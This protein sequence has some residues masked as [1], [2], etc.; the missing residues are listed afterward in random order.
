MLEHAWT[1]G[2]P[3]K[4]VTGDEVYGDSSHLRNVVA[5]HD[6]WYVMAVRTNVTVW[7]ERPEVAVPE[8]KGA[9]R[10][11]TRERI[12]DETIKAMP[13]DRL[14]ASWPESHWQRLAVAEGEKGP[15]IYDWACRRIVEN[16]DELPSRDG[17]LLARRSTSDPDEI[18]YYLSNAP[19][20]TT[21]LRLAQI[22]STRFT[23]EQ[24]FEEGK[25]E[26]GLDHYEVRHWHSW[27]RHITLSM[28][29]H[30]WLASIRLNCNQKKGAKS[31]FLPT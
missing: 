10:K 8:W 29:A 24:C 15:R 9:G 19:A 27:Y 17:W 3:M 1:M 2:V 25:G 6:R 28:M 12:L 4:W 14:V 22:A 21:L 30:A 18:A 31:R 13:A 23:V 5:E 11:P 7:T 16:Q 20:E 26:T